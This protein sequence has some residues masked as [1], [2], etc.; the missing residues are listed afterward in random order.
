MFLRIF[1]SSLGVILVVALLIGVKMSQFQAMGAAAAH[2]APPVDIVT[3]APAQAATWEKNLSATGS[4]MAVQGVTVSAEMAGKVSKI[5]FES[6]AK[7]AAGDL[8]VELDVATEQAQ[9][10]AADA[11]AELSK[12]NLERAKDLRQ[13]ETNSKADLD[14]AEAEAKQTQ[15]A[16]DNLRAIIAKKTIR[17]PFAGQ[18]GLRLVNLGQVLKDGDPIA[19]L[20]TLDPIFV[21]FSMP[22]QRLAQ[23][24]VGSIVRV[25]TDA[26]PGKTFDGKITAINPD[27]DPA[28]R[29]VRLQATLANAE[30]LLRPG[31]FANVTVV[32]PEKA[33][34]LAIPASSVLYAPYGDSVFIVDEKKNEKT[35]QVEKVL[36]QQFVRLGIARGDF[37]AVENGLKAGE[38]VVTSGVFK[39]RP[40]E[41]VTIDNTLAPKPQLQPKPNDT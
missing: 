4:V 8:L 38:M 21:D 40:G 25:T 27:V 35:G 15:A 11:A 20:Q 29:N 32:L 5:A 2:M 18:L 41:L 26:A 33:D 14:A 13:K 22:Q 6:G 37:V 12:V 3:A 9:L 19:S 28:T 1:T 34:V 17:A 36:R 7:V 39:H 31:M 23:L 16:G 30:E 10:R 24:S